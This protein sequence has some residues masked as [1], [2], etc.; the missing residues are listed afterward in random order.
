MHGGRLHHPHHHIG[1]VVVEDGRD[2]VLGEGIC[3][4]ADEHTR[5]ANRACREDMQTKWVTL[6]PTFRRG[7]KAT[8]IPASHVCHV[9]ESARSVRVRV[10]LSCGQ[11]G[12]CFRARWARRRAQSRGGFSPSPTTTHLICFILLQDD[13]HSHIALYLLSLAR[14]MLSLGLWKPRCGQTK[15]IAP[16]GHPPGC[17]GQMA[18]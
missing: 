18:H 10:R 9:C 5:L 13:L 11:L 8:I 6:H 12:W 16:V 2:V 7:R 14:H 15:N 3:C 1:A 17:R 4:V